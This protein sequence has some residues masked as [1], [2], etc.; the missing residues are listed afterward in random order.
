MRERKVHLAIYSAAAVMTAV[1]M[2][3]A[4]NHPASNASS[5]PAAKSNGTAGST[6]AR[7]GGSASGSTGGATG[8][9]AGAPS[10]S[11]SPGST[12]PTSSVPVTSLL[13]PQKKFLGVAMDGVPA[14]LSGLTSVTQQIGKAPNLVA[15]YMPWGTALNQTWVLELLQAGALPVLQFEPQT[16]SIAAI[17]SGGTDDYVRTLADTI[18]RL[19]VPVVVSFGHEMN[20]NWYPWGTT[21]TSPA[22]FVKA[23]QHV[24]DLFVRAGATNAIWMWD[25]NV[26]YPV[27]SIALKPLYPGDA[28]VDWV[29]LTGYY[30]T[31]PGGRSTFDTL[32]LPTMNQVRGFTR[33]PFLLAET[34]ASPST[35]KPTEIANLFAGVE[36]H[37]DVL[38]FIWFDYDKSGTNEANWKFDSDPLSGSTFAQLA[39]G[40]DWGFP[41]G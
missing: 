32:F 20:G 25:A 8:A 4:F 12:A 24:H 31:T 19:N 14:S 7:A 22:D 9:A 16:P 37:A 35:R 10:S 34:G 6:S 18:R 40:S 28:Y 36:A 41:V 38:G 2:L 11:L 15:Y 3:I 21:G 26:T 17:A 30:N 23:W 5:S 29:G 27:P 1:I 33:K 39:K 13:N